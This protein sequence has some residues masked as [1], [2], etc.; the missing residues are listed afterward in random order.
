MGSDDSLN[1]PT[2]PLSDQALVRVAGLSYRYPRGPAALQEVSFQLQP[3]E[4]VGLIGPN[5]AGK[6][7]LFLCLCGVLPV[8]PG[9]ITLAGLDPGIAEHRRRLF[10]RVGLLFQDSDD[11]L[12]QMS[13]RDEVAFGPLNL[14]L[15][16][17]EV[18]RR[19][20][21][22]L[23]C[24]GLSGLEERVPF[25]LSGGE[26]RRL[27]L[28]AVLALHPDILLLDEPTTHL[29]PRG[30]REFVRLI[31]SLPATKLLASHDLEVVRQTCTRVLLL[32]GGRLI[33]DGPTDSLLADAALLEAHG[34]EVPYS[35]RTPSS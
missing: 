28:A 3:G 30:R 23:A 1:C 15:S 8:P 14:G 24:V 2:V 6:T 13:V 31:N 32:D 10:T 35:L 5:G 7:T 17:A 27:A 4:R 21:E 33:A 22:A 12:F 11:Q 25:H 29:D 19:V 34:L 26:K 18:Q 20:A 16:P 9:V